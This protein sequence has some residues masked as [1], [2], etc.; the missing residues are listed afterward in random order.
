MTV[1]RTVLTVA[2]AGLTAYLLAQFGRCRHRGPLG[3][4]PPMRHA[5]GTKTPARWFCDHCLK[6]WPV[7]LEHTTRP[8]ARFTGHDETK[9]P[10]AAERARTLD[11]HRQAA[12]LSRAGFIQTKPP[13][14]RSGPQLAA[15]RR[16]G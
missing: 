9:A 3:L 12:A 16:V 4:L 13:N 1:L 6:T 5:D 11:A 2:S 14:S 10:A 15:P 8:V 7:G